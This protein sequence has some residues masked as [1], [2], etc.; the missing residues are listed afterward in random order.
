MLIMCSE[1]L[2][3][4]VLYSKHKLTFDEEEAVQRSIQNLLFSCGSNLKELQ[5][6]M[7]PTYKNSMINLFERVFVRE[8]ITCDDYI[9]IPYYSSEKFEDICICC[10]CKV[11][12]LVE[13]QYPLCLECKQQGKSPI[14]KRKRKLKT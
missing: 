4:R 9:E 8:N 14:L 13:G 11:S 3:P 2:K 5:V 6:E 10:A 7:H 12:D 1:C